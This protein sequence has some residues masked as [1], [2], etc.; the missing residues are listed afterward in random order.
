MVV[1][2]GQ[3]YA[4][5]LKQAMEFILL[6]LASFFTSVISAVSGMGGG[7]VLL[8]LMTF[9]FSYQTLIPIHG[10]AQ[11]T[12]N[13]ARTLMLKDQVKKELF[14]PFLFG[15]PIG[16]LTA[17]FFLNSALDKSVPKTLIAIMIIYTLFKPKKLP[18]LKIPNWCFIF[19]GFISGI[20]GILVGAT[21]P[22]LAP[23]FLRDDISKEELIASKASMQTITHLIKIPAYIYLGFDYLANFPLLILLIVTAILGTR[24]GIK[25]LHHISEKLFRRIFRSLLFI[26]AVR[27]IYKL[28]FV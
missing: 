21:G 15:A 3:V 24:F 23:F 10:V 22:F 11:L 28:Y 7:V 1:P 6:P 5:L 16:G 20:L 12:S 13:A 18:S 17:T 2:S 8:S 27:I 26:S 25:I 4:I 14:V 19:V 9:M